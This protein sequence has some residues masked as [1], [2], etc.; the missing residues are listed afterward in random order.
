MRTAVTV[1]VV[2]A[3]VG[4]V[5]AL[6]VW[7]SWRSPAALSEEDT[8]LRPLIVDGVG[9]PAGPDAEAMG[10]LDRG[11]IVTGPPL[12]GGVPTDAPRPRPAPRRWRRRSDRSRSHATP[13]GRGPVVSGGERT[14]SAA[15][16]LSAPTS[17]TGR[18]ERQP[19]GGAGMAGVDL[20]SC[21]RPTPLWP[22]EDW[23]GATGSCSSPWGRR[24]HPTSSRT[25][26]PR[27]AGR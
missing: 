10:V 12:P 8:P 6:G 5:A 7:L 11:V 20:S 15:S 1:I 21:P 16:K 19:P 22:S 4:L 23:S 27:T 13:R 17:P 18:S 2:L 9:R 26:A 24:S 3:S 25:A 14:S